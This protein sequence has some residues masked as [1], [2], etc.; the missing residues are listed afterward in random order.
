V[1]DTSANAIAGV[2]GRPLDDMRFVPLQKSR[3][4]VAEE[5]NMQ[6][7]GKEEEEGDDEEEK[8]RGSLQVKVK[9]GMFGDLWIGADCKY[10]YGSRVFTSTDSK[11]GQQR[12]A[13]CWAVDLPHSFGGTQHRFDVVSIHSTRVVLAAAGD[14]EKQRWLAALPTKVHYKSTSVN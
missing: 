4:G 7:E 12:V 11:G 10:D 6:Q 5:S 13:N 9:G 1:W 14:A 8:V 2:E 3:V